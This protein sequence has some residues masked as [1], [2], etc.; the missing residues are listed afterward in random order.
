VARSHLLRPAPRTKLVDVVGDVCGIQAQVMS[1]AELALSA[2]VAGL[3]QE[4]L[5]SELW[6]KRSLVKAWT[7]RGTLHLH[8]A[9]DLPLWAAAARAL[10]EPED[11]KVLDAIG[12]ALDRRCLLREELADAVAKSAGEWTR[13]KIGSGWGYLIGSAAAVGKLCHGPPRGG[14]VTFV[15]TDQWIAWREIDPQEALAEACRRFL[16]T[17]GPAGPRQLAGWLGIKP[18]EAP[19]LPDVRVKPGRA[20][21][22]LRLLPEYDCYVMGFWERDKLVPEKVRDRIKVHPKGRFEGV[23][24]VPTLLIDGVVAGIWRRAKKGKKIEI[25][26]EPA[27][28]LTSEERGELEAE[29]ERIGSFLG[30]EPQL[31]VGRLDA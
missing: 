22:P 3:T 25:A 11:S 18:S 31:R 17:Y 15:R 13:E 21:G 5:R 28:R 2:R 14:K 4:Q 23:A 20:R 7:I 29:A 24:A 9:D 19:P 30:A 16:A 1:A 8:P 10:D 12:D 6:E 26:V 27:Q